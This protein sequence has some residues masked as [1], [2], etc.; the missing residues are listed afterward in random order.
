MLFAQFMIWSYNAVLWILP[1]LLAAV[2]IS[3]WRLAS[4]IAGLQRMIP[5]QQGVAG[6]STGVMT[7]RAAPDDAGALPGQDQVT[8]GTGE[9]LPLSPHPV[10]A[11]TVPAKEPLLRKL[12]RNWMSVAA[13]LLPIFLWPWSLLFICLIQARL[14]AQVDR[15]QQ[16]V[17]PRTDR[18]IAAEVP[19]TG[20]VREN[21]LAEA[22]AP[23][24]HRANRAGTWLGVGVAGVLVAAGLMFGPAGSRWGLLF[25]PLSPW[26]QVGVAVG[27]GFGLMVYGA[28][29]ERRLKR[30]PSQ[31]IAFL[32]FIC[33]GAG[34]FLLYSACAVLVAEGL[35]QTEDAGHLVF[36]ALLL[37]SAFAAILSGV[38]S[39]LLLLLGMT[40]AAM[41]P[42]AVYVP[43]AESSLQHMLLV[44][45]ALALIGLLLERVRLW[46][47][48]V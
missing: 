7:V 25:N 16:A 38:K 41:A 24:P 1:F 21:A 4:R 35:V 13:V 17:A 36:G 3:Q 40:G 46:G 37:I 10:A 2:A 42:F 48:P 44:F 23:E 26:V 18:A 34:L 15:I 31:G 14:V 19:E 39:P 45:A 28:W 30:R 33:A 12:R 27:L 9:T 47:G 22:G 43:R 29:A 20:I 8:S 5:S 11:G 32:P 6:Q